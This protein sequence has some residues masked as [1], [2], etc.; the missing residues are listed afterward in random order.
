MAVLQRLSKVE[1]PREVAEFV[2]GA[3]G[4][5]G[6]VK[7]VLRRSRFHVE[8]S[9]P[10]IL[11]GLLK[12]KTIRKARVLRDA[13]GEEIGPGSGSDDD[14]DEEEE[15]KRRRKRTT[16]TTATTSTT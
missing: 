8:A 4:N 5:F 12:D 15:D 6:K 2:S 3:T 16:M 7:L 1:L 9:D 10:S 14:D 11:R 13:E